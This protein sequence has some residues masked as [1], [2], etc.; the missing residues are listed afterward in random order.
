MKQS[1]KIGVLGT[2]NW[3]RKKHFPTLEY[4]ATRNPERERI[5]IAAVCDIDT[6][7]MNETAD[8]YG[9]PNRFSDFNTFAAHQDIDCY[10]VVV[11]PS[12]LPKLLTRLN[13]NGK[14]ILTEKPP[15]RTHTDAVLL[16][17]KISVPHLVA[18]NRRYFPIVRRFARLL[19]ETPDIYFVQAV[20]TRYNRHDSRPDNPGIPFV[21]GTGIHMI[22]LLEYLFGAISRCDNERIALPNGMDAAW[23]GNLLFGRGVRGRLEILPCCGSQT[24]WIAAHS[25]TRSLYLQGGQ[26]GEIDP[27]G[28]IEIHE[29]ARIREIIRGDAMEHPLVAQGF[30]GE[31]LEF[32]RMVRDTRGCG[33]HSHINSKD[34]PQVRPEPQVRSSSTFATSANSMRIAEAMERGES[35]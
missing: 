32:F 33:A 24:E 10:S 9:I 18:F 3:A 19:A 25:P 27:P 16:R 7:I 31:Y 1:L 26:Y 8:R 20:F 35:V 30:V 4:I 2:G 13:E 12:V 15:G 14:P 22:N 5:E 21:T 6:D 34:R 29:R 28:R 11:N 17:D 23:I